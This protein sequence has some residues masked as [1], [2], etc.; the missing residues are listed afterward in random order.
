MGQASQWATDKD[1]WVLQK[2]DKQNKFE[3]FF[4]IGIWGVPGY[5]FSKEKEKDS[6]TYYDNAKI[7]AQQTALFNAVIIQTDYGRPY[8]NGILKMTGT[9]EFPNELKTYAANK[10]MKNS[11]IPNNAYTRMQE[12]K[13]PANKQ[14]LSDIINKTIDSVNKNNTGDHIWSPIDEVANGLGWNWPVTA[15]E[16]IYKNI[17]AKEKTA[18][19]YT[20]LMGTGKGNT[21]LFEQRY[22]QKNN[23]LPST[24]PYQVLKPEELSYAKDSLLGFNQ[25]YNGYPQYEFKNGTYAYKQYAIDTLKK[26]WFENVKC[27][28]AS[29]KNGG[30]V[31]GVNA[32]LDF[33]AYPV[34]AGITVDAIKA[35]AGAKI[36]VWLYFDGNGYARPKKISVNDYTEIV[37]CQI[38][39]S[40]IHGATGIMFWSDLRNSVENFDVIISVVKELK[41]NLQIIYMKTLQ[42]RWEGDLHYIIKQDGNGKKYIIASN[43]SKTNAA[44]LNISKLKRILKPIEVYISA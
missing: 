39:T 10:V 4:A 30:D 25:A 12:L 20:D 37:R 3:K 17:K 5:E 32:F 14:E 24:P 38:Y 31:F 16:A 6:A 33:Y 23:S 21:F 13:K 44:Q 22:L 29:Y 19:V 15:V 35:G 36:P 7:F 2:K 8:M 41:N 1:G 43:T 40:I 27:T 11:T 26:L 34:L 9:S 28:A 18:L 42:S